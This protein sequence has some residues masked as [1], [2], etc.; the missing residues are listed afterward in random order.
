MKKS[1]TAQ[2]TTIVLNLLLPVCLAFSQIPQAAPD[3]NPPP[4]GGYP[5]GNTA[6]GQ[7][8]LL[9][10]SGGFYN[11]AFGIYSLLS[12]TNGSFNT[13]DGAGTLLLNNANENATEWLVSSA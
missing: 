8:A 6:E 7:L 12:L 5:G 10:L 13:G 2:T 4:D 1:I 9:H 3:V 11:N